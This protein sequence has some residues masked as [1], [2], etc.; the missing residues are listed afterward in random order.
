MLPG[1]HIPNMWRVE[2]PNKEPLVLPGL[3]IPN[4]W[5]VEKPNKESL[6]LYRVTYTEYVK[7]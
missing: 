7:G 2:K 4:M 3:H 1:L 5:R 6:E